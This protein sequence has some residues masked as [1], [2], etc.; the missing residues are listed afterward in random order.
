VVEGESCFVHASAERPERWTYV[1]GPGAA[2]KSISA[3]GATRV[4]SGH[5]HDPAL[6]IESRPGVSVPF[7]PRAGTTIPIA[8]GRRWLAIPGSLGQPRDGNP[9]AAYALV[10]D[11]G[12]WIRFHRVPYDHYAAAAKVRAAGLPEALAYRLERGA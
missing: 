8:A 1:D 3:S 6:F 5:V 9:A 2:Q 7:L 12:R 11:D 10:D 4:F